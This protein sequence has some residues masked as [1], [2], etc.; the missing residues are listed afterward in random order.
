MDER[1]TQRMLAALLCVSALL[2]LTAWRLLGS[3]PS[4]GEVLASLDTPTVEIVAVDDPPPPP[5]EPELPT[6]PEPPVEP[7]EPAPV[8]RPEPRD[9][10]PSDPPPADVPPPPTEEPPA[11]ALEA[12][13]DFTGVTMTNDTGAGGWQSAVGNGESMQGPI[14][15]PGARVTGRRREGVVGGAPGGTGTATAPSGPRVVALSDLSRRPSPRGDT[16][17]VLQRNYPP[18]A[19]QLGIEGRAA[20]AFR[21]MPDGTVVRV[22]V[23]SEDPADQNFG[24]ACRRTVEQIAWEPPIAADGQA[25]AVDASFECEFSVGL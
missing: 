9:P 4:V 8:V 21:I 6:D 3:L 11:P 24:Q 19:R 23:R 2:H 17:A 16:N 14:G 20:V 22:R 12:E 13:E 15:P 18:R 7:D 25:V 5:P 1:I 10:R